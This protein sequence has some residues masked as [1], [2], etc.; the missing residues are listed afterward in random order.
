MAKKDPRVAVSAVL[1]N[2]MF[3]DFAQLATQGGTAVLKTT[4]CCAN[5]ASKANL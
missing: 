2:I 4:L 5:F 1:E 3:R